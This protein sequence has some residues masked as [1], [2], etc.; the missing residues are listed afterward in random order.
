VHTL[1]RVAR[2]H[3]ISLARD[4]ECYAYIGGVDAASNAVS[5]DEYEKNAGREGHILCELGDD[6]AGRL[7]P[8]EQVKYPEDE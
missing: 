2:A 6:P 3:G 7:G 4:P 5:R 1:I 8:V